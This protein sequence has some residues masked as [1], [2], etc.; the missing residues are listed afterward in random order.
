VEGNGVTDA[1]LKDYAKAIDY[2]KLATLP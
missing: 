2:T 1:D